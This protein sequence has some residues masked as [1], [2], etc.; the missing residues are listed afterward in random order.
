MTLFHSHVLP[1]HLNNVTKNLLPN[2]ESELQQ[3]KSRTGCMKKRKAVVIKL[4]GNKRMNWLQHQWVPMR[5]LCKKVNQWMSFAEKWKW[6][7]INYLRSNGFR[8]WVCSTN[9]NLV[10]VY[11]IYCQLHWLCH[12][13]LFIVTSILDFITSSINLNRLQNSSR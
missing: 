11:S 3:L 8:W 13:H 5:R 10:L 6:K 4:A 9:N 1:Q 12:I 2:G 7:L